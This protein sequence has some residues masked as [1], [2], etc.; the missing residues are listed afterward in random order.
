MMRATPSRVMTAGSE[1]KTSPKPNESGGRMETV[2]NACSLSR[3]GA[4]NSSQRGADAVIGC[5]F[6]AHDIEA[7]STVDFAIWLSE[8]GSYGTPGSRQ[9]PRRGIPAR[10]CDFD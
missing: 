7:C 6:R 9:K 8:S 5:A 3:M 1:R 2:S 10:A 4:N